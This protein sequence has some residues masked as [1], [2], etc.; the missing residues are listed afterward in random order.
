MDDKTL[1]HA[2]TEELE[3][4]RH[5]DA[6]HIEVAVHDGVVQLAGYVGT[7]AEKKAANRSVWHLRGIV[8]VRDDIE[9]RQATAHQHP[10]EELARRAQQV[11]SLGFT[12][13][14]YE[15]RSTEWIMVERR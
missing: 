4:A 12:D 1:Q 15:N 2:V 13:T 6:S 14:W 9:V 3:W 5:V 7:L 8:G 10:D 11:P